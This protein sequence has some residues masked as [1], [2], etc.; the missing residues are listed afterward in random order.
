MLGNERT[1]KTLHS[2]SFKLSV[3]LMLCRCWRSS[4]GGGSYAVTRLE[5]SRG[6]WVFGTA[7]EQRDPERE[8]KT[9]SVLLRDQ[10]LMKLLLQDEQSSECL[11]YSRKISVSLLFIQW[12][13]SQ[14]PLFLQ[15]TIRTTVW[16]KK[17]F[18]FHFNIL[19]SL[20][21][22]SLF[23]LRSSHHSF[24]LTDSS[25]LLISHSIWYFCWA[26]NIRIFN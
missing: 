14:L 7:G 17:W 2:R 8:P 26:D 19:K 13:L 25:Q 23:N 11:N 22:L 3:S 20:T 24:E 18:Y 12:L 16:L 10:R 4:S 21:G 1:I 6:R 5:I 15:Q 9:E